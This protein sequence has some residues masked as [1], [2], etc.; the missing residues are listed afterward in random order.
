MIKV[1]AFDLDDTLWPVR[2]VLLRAEKVLGNWLEG[3]G[4]RYDVAAMRQIRSELL[5]SAPDLAGQITLLRLKVIEETL[6]RSGVA[7]VSARRIAEEAIDVFLVARHQIDFF[8]GAREALLS[9]ADQFQL[10]ALSNGN[11]DI[12]RLGLDNIFSFAFS[13]EQVGAPKPAD[14]LFRAALAHTSTDPH[15]MVYVG[16]DARLD[17]DPAKRLGLYTVWIRHADDAAIGEELPDAVV[18]HIRDVPEAI[19]KLFLGS[20]R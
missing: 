10:G 20:Q 8:D 18:P 3:A 6:R 7:T 11:A 5:H 13:A 4:F 19:N 15:E 9:L 1:I 2:P 14:N 17:M 16:D 12:R